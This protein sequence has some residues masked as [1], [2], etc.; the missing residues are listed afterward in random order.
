[1]TEPNDP[2]QPSRKDPSREPPTI[3]LEATVVDEAPPSEAEAGPA[4]AESALHDAPAEPA[5]EPLAAPPGDVPERPAEMPARPARSGPALVLAGLLGGAVGAGLVLA[6]EAWRKPA[7]PTADPRIAAL[8][9]QSAALASRDGLRNVEE[10]VASL[11]NARAPVEQRLQAVQE[12]AGRATARAEAAYNRPLPTAP[13]AAPPDDS[14]LKELAAKVADVDKRVADTAQRVTETAQRTAG[15]NEAI[16]RLV[17][18]QEQRL[19]RQDERLA[20]LAREVA[21]GGSDATR[22]GTRVVLA[23]RLADALRD[24]APY[25]EVLGA[26]GRFGTDPARL[27]P[28]EPFSRQGAPTGAAMAQAFKPLGETM[29]RESRSGSSVTDRILRMTERVV[30]IR[31]LTE[32]GSTSVPGLV[33][34]IEDALEKGR[35]D[36]AVAAY[37]AL[38]EPARRSAQAFGQQ[39]KERAAADAASRA[40]A[41]DAVAALDPATR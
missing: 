23:Q 34:G 6:V 25:P 38:P 8:Q 36:Q 32:T 17:A 37:D 5:E 10:R 30:S 11:E 39:L 41:A 21:E 20:A 1:M 19:V 28:L 27:A 31:S 24:G 12:A 29:I 9:E 14:A 16:E 40:I 7:L 3:D 13:A 22:A 18:A 15:A 2:H 26:L 33:A 4:E 35:F